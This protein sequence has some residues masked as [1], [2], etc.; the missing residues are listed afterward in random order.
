MK[1]TFALAALAATVLANPV[2]QA[3]TADITPT[4]AAPP[5][6]SPTFPGTFVI[7]ITNVTT[8]SGKRD[9]GDGLDKVCSES[10]CTL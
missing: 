10:S 8:T 5:G 2:P 7:T 4:A 1:Y 6:C 3:I 9:I